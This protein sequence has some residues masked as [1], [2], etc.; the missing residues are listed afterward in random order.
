MASSITRFD[1]ENFNEKNDFWLWQ[2]KMRALMVQQGCDTALETLPADMES[3]EK[4]DLMKKAHSTK[5]GDHIDAFNKLI[6]DLANIDIEIEDKDQTLMLLTSLPSKELKAQKEETGDG[7]Y[8]KGRSD[9]SGKAHSGGSSRFKS[10]GGI[11]KLKCFI[12]HSDGHLKRYCPIKKSSGFTN[13]TPWTISLQ[14]TNTPDRE[15]KDTIARWI[16]L[17]GVHE[18]QV[19]KRVW[20]EVKLQG[21]QGNRKR[22]TLGTKGDEATTK[23]NGQEDA[24][25]NVVEKKKVKESMEANL[26]KLL[27][28]NGAD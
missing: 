19:D 12:C 16:K 23:Y 8:V 4:A 28:Y 1:I 22:Y 3:C 24:E 10:R 11:S 27:K 15:S 17:S 25:G 9:R 5:L 18:V 21:A 14:K 7:L 2:I 20:F 13:S 6:L 26:G